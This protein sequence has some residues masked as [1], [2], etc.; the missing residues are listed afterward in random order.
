[1]LL[2][3]LL[4]VLM[5]ENMRGAGNEFNQN[6]SINSISSCVTRIVERATPQLV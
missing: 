6:D 1:M 2:R 3:Q 4:Q 5:R